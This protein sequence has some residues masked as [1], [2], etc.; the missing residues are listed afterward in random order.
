MIKGDQ[1]NAA[2]Y[3]LRAAKANYAA[4]YLFLAYIELDARDA[5]I[6]Y[7]FNLLKLASDHGNSQA[8]RELGVRLV[9]FENDEELYQRGI[10]FLQLAKKHGN[11]LAGIDLAMQYIVNVRF[12]NDATAQESAKR[13]LENEVAD[14]NGIAKAALAIS[15][16]AGL[17]DSQSM[18]VLPALPEIQ[19]QIKEGSG[20]IAGFL[21]LVRHKI[22]QDT[23]AGSAL[24]KSL[25]YWPK[26]STVDHEYF[27]EECGGKSLE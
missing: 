1:V 25:C 21:Y 17:L 6:E 16:Q 9:Q 12:L 8:A 20:G 14:G 15:E 2:K 13:I 24:F 5:D 18:D 23:Q 10:Q 4:S 22:R 26:M 19:N 11:S 7:A 27:I 3:V